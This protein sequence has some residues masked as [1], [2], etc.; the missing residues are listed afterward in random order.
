MDKLLVLWGLLPLL[1][2]CGKEPNNTI[3]IP[4]P[5]EKVPTSITLSSASLAPAQAGESF[6]LTITSPVQPEVSAPPEWISTTLGAYK[7][8]KMQVTVKV[9]ANETYEA[10]TANLTVSASGVP[11]VNLKVTQNGRTVVPDPTLPNN[12]AI[13]WM[14]QL[15][16]G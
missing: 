1:L 9:A 15:G 5:S 11:S 2:A 16:V 6:T 10:R 3:V 8:Y 14:K 7:N 4:T 13:K 12:A